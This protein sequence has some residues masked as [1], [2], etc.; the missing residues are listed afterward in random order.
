MNTPY[1]IVPIAL[2]SLTAVSGATADLNADYE[3]LL[4]RREAL[5]VEL[6]KRPVLEHVLL[7]LDEGA[8]HDELWLTMRRA[9]SGWCAATARCPAGTRAP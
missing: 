4:A 6:E 7:R 9:K 3:A 2:L 5:L 1:G 8:D